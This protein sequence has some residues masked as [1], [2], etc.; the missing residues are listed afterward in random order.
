MKSVKFE[1]GYAILGDFMSADVQECIDRFTC[2]TLDFVHADPPYGNVA[3]GE[4][5]RVLTTDAAFADWMRA[6]TKLL[7]KRITDRGSLFVWGGI[8]K[9]Q[10]RP[11][12]RYLVE[13][14]LDGDF[15]LAN[16]ITWKKKRAYGLAHNLLFVRE[17]LA[18]LHKGTDIKKPLIFNIPL[19]DK[20]RGYAG[21]NA[22]YPAKSEFL[23]RTNV[24]DDV[25]EIF[26]GKMHE[27]QKPVALVEIPILMCS[28][29]GTLVLDP[30]AG[31]GSTAIAARKNDREFI[32]VEKDPVAFE[33]MVA[34]I[35]SGS[36]L[37]VV[38]GME[39]K[40]TAL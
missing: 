32:V 34:R 14:E 27:A 1:D 26:K 13:V 36:L 21:Y 38:P 33:R 19:L 7:A 37:D 28:E 3:Q 10:F 40:E 15:L 9:P 8:G 31:S 12:Y 16:H 35:R 17:E 6:W 39:L 25:S 11:F 24:W 5:D 4:W 29:P 23:R 18:W 20:L 2:G 22:D 30:F